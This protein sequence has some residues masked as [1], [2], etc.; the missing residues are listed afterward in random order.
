MGYIPELIVKD[1]FN[2]GATTA[3][4]FNDV[5]EAEEVHLHLFHL[6]I[7]VVVD[8]LGESFISRSVVL[9]CLVISGSSVECDISHQ[10]GAV[11]GDGDG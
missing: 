1:V 7:S 4:P 6:S 3:D 5:G 9:S 10:R 8:R 11:L 2:D